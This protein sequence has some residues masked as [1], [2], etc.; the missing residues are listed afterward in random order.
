MAQKQQ[1]RKRKTVWQLDDTTKYVH[2]GDF[3]YPKAMTSSHNKNDPDTLAER[4]EYIREQAVTKISQTRVNEVK[5]QIKWWA[6]RIS[7][8]K[9]LRGKRPFDTENATKLVIDAFSVESQ[10]LSASELPHQ[11]SYFDSMIASRVM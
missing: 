1:M 7:I 2:L 3:N 6:F 11:R 10:L 4:R 5:P 8:E 9:Q